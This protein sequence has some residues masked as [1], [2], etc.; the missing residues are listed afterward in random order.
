MVLSENEQ[1]DVSDYEQPSLPGF[2]A[3]S[4]LPDEYNVTD[5]HQEGSLEKTKRVQGGVATTDLVLSAYQC[6]N[7]DIFPKI[8][9]L[10]VPKDAL[11]ADVTYGKGVFRKNVRAGASK[12]LSSDVHKLD[13][14]FQADCRALPYKSAILDCLVLDPPYMES[15]LR[16]TEEHRG[17][18][19]THV[20]F[21]EAY[22]G[23]VP[24]NGQNPSDEPKKWHAAVIDL[25]AKAGR[26]AYRVL[27]KDGIFIVKCQDE[28]SAGKQWL[29][30]VELINEYAS[31]GFYAKD[32]FVVMR[33][34]KPGVSRIKKQLHARK[35]HS[36]FL[37]FVKVN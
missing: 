22:R 27:R 14:T 10:H 16:D 12:L 24:E 8:L 18:V 25:Y 19:G 6:D 32:L 21:R 1:S 2:T 31:I 3:A 4:E 13:T 29:T 7:A 20:T 37:V 17:A 5:S 28:V 15:L 33:T 35:N 9:E 26:E 36:Y 11:I 30:H 34:N 23:G